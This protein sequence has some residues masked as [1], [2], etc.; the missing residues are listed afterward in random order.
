MNDGRLGLSLWVNNEPVRPVSLADF[1]EIKRQKI[2]GNRFVCNCATDSIPDISWSIVVLVYENTLYR[3]DILKLPEGKENVLVDPE[4][5]LEC[6]THPELQKKNYFISKGLENTVVRFLDS[7]FGF[8]FDRHE[9]P[10]ISVFHAPGSL[11]RGT[12]K[13]ITAWASGKGISAI[14]ETRLLG[15]YE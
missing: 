3:I 13:L 1:I 9:E 10:G 4:M 12:L 8:A 11:T 7:P 6:G 5:R 15:I 2:S 14:N